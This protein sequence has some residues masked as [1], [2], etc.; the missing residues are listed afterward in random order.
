[1]PKMNRRQLRKMILKEMGNPLNPSYGQGMRQ[2]RAIAD[3]ATFP[4]ADYIIDGLLKV[5]DE[6]AVEGFESQEARSAILSLQDVSSPDDFYELM[7][8][9][10]G[11]IADALRAQ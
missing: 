5:L 4:A 10:E 9:I 8:D 7:V 2:Q 1:M 11:Y 3:R 6:M